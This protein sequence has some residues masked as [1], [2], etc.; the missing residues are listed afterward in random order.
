MS[1]GKKFE[2]TEG[3]LALV[4]STQKTRRAQILAATVES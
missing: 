3:S 1:G 2:K 4:V